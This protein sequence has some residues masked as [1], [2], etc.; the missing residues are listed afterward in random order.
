MRMENHLKI[1]KLTM[2][3]T[4]S[5]NSDNSQRMCNFL[6]DHCA[7]YTQLT[8][9]VPR[10]PRALHCRLYQ[11]TSN[12]VNLVQVLYNTKL[13]RSY[14][15]GAVCN[16]TI[17][18]NLAVSNCGRCGFLTAPFCPNISNNA[19]DENINVRSRAIHCA[20]TNEFFPEIDA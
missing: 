19:Q 9:F 11:N 13:T 12:Q 7:S 1:C 2:C 6:P 8:G 5:E 18:V 10:G 4:I 20:R 3:Q 17:G 15:V 14:S 16:R